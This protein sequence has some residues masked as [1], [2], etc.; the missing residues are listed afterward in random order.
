VERKRF[1]KWRVGLT[2]ST[3]CVVEI[4]AESAQIAC[5][6]AVEECFRDPD[7][8][9]TAHSTHVTSCLIN[10]KESDCFATYI[11]ERIE[12]SPDDE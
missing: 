10:D 7:Y 6:A 8:Y 2:I 12:R 4:E 9:R 1:P 5:E 11:P 3:H